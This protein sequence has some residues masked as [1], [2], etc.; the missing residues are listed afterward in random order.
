M[1]VHYKLIRALFF[2]GVF[3]LWSCLV[4]S[5]DFISQA[6]QLI[7]HW[8]SGYQNILWLK[9]NS[10]LTTFG[11][12]RFI[13]PFIFL[14]SLSFFIK[15]KNRYEF[16]DFGI[17]VLALSLNLLTK[18]IFQRLR[19]EYY[20]TNLSLTTFAYPSG[21]ALGGILLMGFLLYVI[22]K[23]FFHKSLLIKI[24]V[25]LPCLWIAASRVFLGVHWLSDVVG[26][27]LIGLFWLEVLLLL[28]PKTVGPGLA[29]P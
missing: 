1:D 29:V 3:V 15:N 21:H 24:V 2:L 20:L 14:M 7:Y 23:T 11:D 27:I 4:F 9:F 19:P 5:V 12:A 22:Q 8:F 26:G 10:W 25:V 13:L 18:N 17:T 16:I 6:D 28:K